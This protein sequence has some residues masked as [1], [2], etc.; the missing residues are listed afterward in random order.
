MEQTRTRPVIAAR[1][2]LGTINHT[3]LTI[4]ALQ[5][6]RMPPPGIVLIDGGEACTPR[7]MIEENIQ[8]IERASGVH[9]SGVIPRIADFDRPLD[10]LDPVLKDIAGC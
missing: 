9:V 10:F 1:A 7:A 2:G 8:A 5:S 4:E 6:R 3:L